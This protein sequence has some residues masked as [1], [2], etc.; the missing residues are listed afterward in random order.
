MG[1]G[2]GVFLYF[3]IICVYEGMDTFGRFKI[4]L[5]F[6]IRFYYYFIFLS[7]LLL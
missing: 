1:G 2:G 3:H 5:N 6:F 7:F 4:E